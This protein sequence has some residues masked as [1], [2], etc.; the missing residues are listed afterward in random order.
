[1]GETRD[2][3][4]PSS[5]A[6]IRR[7]RKLLAV[8]SGKRDGKRFKTDGGSIGWRK[9]S[10]GAYAGGGWHVTHALAAS[11]RAET[12]IDCHQCACAKESYI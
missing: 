2:L 11:G 3:L 7:R 12:S 9:S 5:R 10:G 4:H 1:M 8:D 6:L